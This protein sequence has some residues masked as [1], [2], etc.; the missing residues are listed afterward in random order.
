MDIPKVPTIIPTTPIRA[1]RRKVSAVANKTRHVLYWIAAWVC[2][3]TLV[4]TCQ[5][6]AAPSPNGNR[7]GLVE[8]DHYPY[9]KTNNPRHPY[10][11]ISY[12]GRRRAFGMY[13]FA[14]VSLYQ[15]KFVIDKQDTLGNPTDY[16]A[17]Q[18]NL[19]GG[20]ISPKWNSPVGSL[21]L[22]LAAGVYQVPTTA[23]G[24]TGVIA[25]I[26]QGGVSWTLDTV[27]PNPYV[28]P[29]V[30]AGYYR[31]NYTETGSNHLISKTT[32]IAPY[33]AGG[34]LVQLN[35]LDLKDS[36]SLWQQTGIINTYLYLEGR[37]W[38]RGAPTEPD[39]SSPMAYAAGLKL[40]F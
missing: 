19:T 2:A 30:S 12:R 32:S 39:F 3:L 34:V 16:S 38:L 14:G 36:I 26:F 31:V 25:T 35:W 37:S 1:V 11:P 23:G 20:G 21:G 4:L 18:T 22:D 8:V 15:P 13:F 28:A 9:V 27:L 40:E 10:R 7:H 33:V 5:A 29:Y 24:G 17:A 6:N